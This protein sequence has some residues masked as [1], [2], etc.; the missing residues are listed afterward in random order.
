MHFFTKYRQIK[1]RMI[2]IIFLYTQHRR[3][4]KL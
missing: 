2:K 1:I 4:A 3:I